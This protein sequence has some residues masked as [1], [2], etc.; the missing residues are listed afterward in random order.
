[1]MFMLLL[2]CMLISMPLLLIWIV[3]V[4]VYL[5]VLKGKVCLWSGVWNTVWPK[6]GV[7]R[8]RNGSHG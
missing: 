5:A 3:L 7:Q 4:S 2:G 8:D 1:M 6:F